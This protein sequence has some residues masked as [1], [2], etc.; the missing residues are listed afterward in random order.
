M[1]ERI[2]HCGE[3]GYGGV[4]AREGLVAAGGGELRDPV[5]HCENCVAAGDLPLTV[6]A[7]AREAVAD[8]DGTQ[9]AACRAEHYRSVVLDRVLMRAPAQLSASYLRLLA[10]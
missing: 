6:S 3:T 9:N 4:G 1:V 8:L 5:L 7:V 2:A 10:G